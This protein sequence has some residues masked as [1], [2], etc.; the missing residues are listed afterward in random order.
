[1]QND[2]KKKIYMYNVLLFF[3]TKDQFGFDCF[4]M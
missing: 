4:K 1:M 2:K 3:I